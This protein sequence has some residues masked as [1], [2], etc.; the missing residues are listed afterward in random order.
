[1]EALVLRDGGVRQPV[2]DPVNRT[3]G[4]AAAIALDTA[5]ATMTWRER[6]RKERRERRRRDYYEDRRYYWR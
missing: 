1:M 2:E 5:R 6:E 4:A 3:R